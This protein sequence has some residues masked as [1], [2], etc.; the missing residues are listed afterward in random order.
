MTLPEAINHLKEKL[1]EPDTF[2]CQAC[3]EEHKQLLEWLLEL[4][5][6][7]NRDEVDGWMVK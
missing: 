7:R 3:Q 5:D 6:R 2:S 4:Q 1:S